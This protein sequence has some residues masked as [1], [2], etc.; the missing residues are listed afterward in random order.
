M[1]DTFSGAPGFSAPVFEVDYAPRKPACDVLLLGSAHA[2]FGRPV[3]RMQVGLRVGSMNKQFDVVGDRVWQAGLSGI[4]AS[5]PRPFTQMPI[6]Y[7]CAFGGVDQ[8]PEDPAEHDAYLPNPVGRGWRKHLKNS[9][10]DGKPLP[11]TEES[12]APVSWPTNKYRP[13]AFGPVGRGWPQRARHAGTYDQQWL[14]DVFPFLPQDFDERFFQAAGVDQQVALPRAPLTVALEG[15]TPD[16]LR[17]FE[18]PHLEAPVHVFPKHGGREDLVAPLDTI[19]LEP[20]AQ[21]I[22]MTW[23]I[24]RPLRK[25]MHEIAQVMIGKKGRE[26]WQQRER[27]TFPVP[28]IMVPIPPPSTSA[29]L[30]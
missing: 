7:D 11:N 21:R 19:V 9:W 24:A 30:V 23:R 18:L 17:C 14:D 27:L 8:E 16:G 20:Q 1:A 12:G 3:E 10:V 26:W 13:M 15:L 28:V 6:S 29:E 25:N 2:P 22:T 5:T 4:R